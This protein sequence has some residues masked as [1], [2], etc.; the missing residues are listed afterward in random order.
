MVK[1]EASQSPTITVSITELVV[2]TEITS[3]GVSP[4]DII[5]GESAV[6]GGFLSTTETWWTEWAEWAITNLGLSIIP[7]MPKAL[8]GIPNA[9]ITININGIPTLSA[10]TGA[11]GRFEATFAPDTPGTYTIQAVF[12]GMSI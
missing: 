12:E 1:Y 9:P 8:G 4:A 2:P 7:G 10:T 6:I 5:L 3:F 11:D